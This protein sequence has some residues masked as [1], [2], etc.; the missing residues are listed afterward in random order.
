MA[1]GGRKRKG[2]DRDKRRKA[3]LDR[4][5]AGDGE[6]GAARKA[7]ARDAAAHAAAAEP[8]AARWLVAGDDGVQ[9]R[10]VVAELLGLDVRT[11]LQGRGSDRL[12]ELAAA[13]NELVGLGAVAPSGQPLLEVFVDDEAARD[14]LSPA[15][16]LDALLTGEAPAASTHDRAVRMAQALL[17]IARRHRDGEVDLHARVAPPRTPRH[18][19]ADEVDALLAIGLPEG[20]RRPASVEP[21]ITLT[22]SG[23]LGASPWE[24]VVIA[25]R[26]LATGPIAGPIGEGIATWL[27]TVADGRADD[28]SRALSML[29]P[30][31]AGLLLRDAATRAGSDHPR[32]V[33]EIIAEL[34]A[35]RMPFG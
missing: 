28:W 33:A 11:S 7:Q 23:W 20:L 25:G 3:Q 22:E 34:V 2:G 30:F 5:A 10:D 16:D 29:V 21:A 31:D 6:A 19:G 18:P 27:H 14:A 15:L 12:R 32:V 4:L 35:T 13:V 17:E 24:L 8:S 1:K 9:A 26:G